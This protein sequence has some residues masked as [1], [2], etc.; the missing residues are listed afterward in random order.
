MNKVKWNGPRGWT[1][2]MADLVSPRQTIN[3]DGELEVLRAKLNERHIKDVLGR[4]W[5]KQRMRVC[6]SLLCDP[7]DEMLTDDEIAVLFGVMNANQGH[8]YQVITHNPARMRLWF[9]NYDIDRIGVVTVDY[10]S[11]LGIETGCGSAFDPDV[12][13]MN[14][15][16]LGVYVSSQA[17]AHERIPELLRT[18]ARLRFA[19][20]L[21]LTEDVSLDPPM[22][23]N[24]PGGVVGG[25][26]AKSEEVSWTEGTPFCVHCQTEAT[27]GWWL[28]WL[29][30][31]EASGIN[32]VVVGGDAGPNARPFNLDWARHI[33]ADC[34]NASVPCFVQQLGAFAQGEWLPPGVRLGTRLLK[35]CRDRDPAKHR[36]LLE[37]PA[38]D[39][40]TEWPDDLQVQQLPKDE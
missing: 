30:D 23:D 40:L 21:P 29:P 28:N 18:P 5:S 15:V 8:T 37:A 31:E 22:C 9:E 2:A 13:P 17:A 16:E 3:F 14:N 24:C 4:R 38:G 12:W 36:F 35:D 7:F 32:W 34:K 27:F 6:L 25:A 19:F 10:L 11:K 20:C 33:V 1:D 26:P 39:D